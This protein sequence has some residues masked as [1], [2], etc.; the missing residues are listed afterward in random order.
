[1]VIADF[2]KDAHLTR[3]AADVD[4][5]QCFATPVLSAIIQARDKT[6]AFLLAI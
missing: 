4:Q 1:V 6:C 5:S 3:H 2:G